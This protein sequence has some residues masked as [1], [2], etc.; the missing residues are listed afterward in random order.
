[1][2]YLASHEQTKKP[3][4]VVIASNQMGELR[5]LP[6]TVISGN[7]ADPFNP[8]QRN[9][10]SSLI[11]PAEH[12]PPENANASLDNDLFEA[13]ATAKIMTS[14]VSMYLREGW[15]EK[16][17]YQLDLLLDPQEWDPQDI[18]LKAQ[19]FD[20]FLK[21]ICDINP[22]KKPG[23]GISNTGNLVAGWR[24]GENGEDRVSLEFEPNDRVIL[25]GS[26]VIDGQIESFSARTVVRNLKKTLVNMNCTQWL[27]CD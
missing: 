3:V 4:G 15:R 27:I 13:S 24:G 20:T 18:P 5:S 7:Q 17:F 14:R 25:I 23:M 8:P 12:S 2:M 19:S 16:L 1:M 21:A 11:Y 6:T 26:R 9:I 10:T 22:T